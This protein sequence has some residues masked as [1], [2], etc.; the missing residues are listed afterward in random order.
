MSHRGGHGAA[1]AVSG[2]NF[3]P[4]TSLTLDCVVLDLQ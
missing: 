2:P 3:K 1:K 4:L